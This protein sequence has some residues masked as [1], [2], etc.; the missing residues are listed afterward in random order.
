MVDFEYYLELARTCDAV[1]NLYLEYTLDD[2]MDP[3][4][5]Y[6][7]AVKASLEKSDES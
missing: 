1:K 2:G 4:V 7:L 5:A 3:A 6:E